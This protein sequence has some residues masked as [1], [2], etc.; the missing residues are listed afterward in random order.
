MASNE[1]IAGENTIDSI[2]GPLLNGNPTDLMADFDSP[3]NPELSV[4]G[5]SKPLPLEYC[6]SGGDSGGGLFREKGGKWELIGICHRSTM[7]VE[8]LVKY[9]YYGEIMRWTRVSA[10]RDWIDKTRKLQH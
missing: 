4:M 2:S 10:F 9:G 6:F 8:L 1:K 7:T 5:D 3:L